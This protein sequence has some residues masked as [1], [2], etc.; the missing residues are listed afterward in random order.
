LH[1]QGAKFD[2]ENSAWKWVRE[3]ALS[4]HRV[5]SGRGHKYRLHDPS[6]AIL[7]PLATIGILLGIAALPIGRNL[8]PIEYADELERHLH[9]IDSDDEWDRT[10]SV[11]LKNPRLERLRQSLPD[12]FNDLKTEDDRMSLQQIIRALRNDEFSEYG[13][14]APKDSS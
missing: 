2:N 14:A 9:G 7:V 5:R 12:S 13:V 8:S 6:W 4:R 10:A 3:I 1:V 11:R